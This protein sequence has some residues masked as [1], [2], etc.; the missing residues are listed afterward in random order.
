M[1]VQELYAAIGGD[2]DSAKR[3]LQMDMLIGKF[4]VKL[5]D[6]QSCQRLLAAADAGDAAGIFEGAHAMKG[7]CA[8]LGLNS[9][10]QA[11]S[12]IAEEFRPG[13]GRTMDQAE[14]EARVR[15]LKAQYD[16]TVEGIR[17]FAAE[18]G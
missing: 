2:Y 12:A 18:E 8:N 9:L 17:A 16:R 3:V 6:D 14:L 15:D 7:I 5:L 1:T 13:S 4:V 11:A 10:S